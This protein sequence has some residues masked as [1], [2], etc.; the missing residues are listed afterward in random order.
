M[1]KHIVVIVPIVVLVMAKAGYCWGE[2]KSHPAISETAAANSILDSYLK[3]QLNLKNGSQAELHW[4]FPSDILKI[5][6][7]VGEDDSDKDRSINDWIRLGGTLEDVDMIRGPAWRPRHHFHN[8]INNE[9]LDNQTDHPNW[10]ELLRNVNW[11]SLG[12]IQGG[13]TPNGES[14][15]HWATKGFDRGGRVP[16]YNHYYW[17]SAREDFMRSLTLDNKTM[18]EANL[19]NALLDLG[20]VCHLLEDMG[21]PAHTRNDFIYGH[22][23]GNRWT[24]NYFEDW[25]E[26]QIVNN[27]GKLLGQWIV[28][29]QPIV[30]N[31]V[32]KYFDT[33]A[34]TGQYIGG[35]LPDSSWGLAEQTNFQFLSTSTSFECS[36]TKYQFT[37]PASNRLNNPVKEPK[38][39]GFAMYYSGYGVQHLAEESF[40][41]YIARI[42]ADRDIE[43]MQVTDKTN[44]PDVE[45][46]CK[47]YAT[48]SI[49][50][51][52]NYTTGLINYFFRGR[53][54]VAVCCPTGCY[55][56]GSVGKVRYDLTITNISK[57]TDREQVLK[58]GKFEFYWDDNSG[59]RTKLNDQQFI[60]YN[61]DPANPNTTIPWNEQ[62]YLPYNKSIKAKA[63]FDL[64][65]GKTCEDVNDF[66]IVY[67]GA[68]SQMPEEGKPIEVDEDD[69]N[70][71][72]CWTKSTSINV[73]PLLYKFYL[74]G[75]GGD[76]SLH[77]CAEYLQ[78]IY[79]IDHHDHSP[80]GPGYTLL[81]WRD[82]EPRD[83]RW[84]VMSYH[85]CDIGSW[86]CPTSCN[87]S[88]DMRIY[89]KFDSSKLVYPI[90]TDTFS[91]QITPF[92]WTRCSNRSTGT[93]CEK[94]IYKK[95]FYRDIVGGETYEDFWSR[96]FLGGVFGDGSDP[97]CNESGCKIE[98]KS[99]EIKTNSWVR[100]KWEPQF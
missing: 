77:D 52:I 23:L 25:V 35:N 83:C 58:G 55:M 51:T 32:R 10:S 64:P 93:Y 80:V 84:Q 42:K 36:G 8:P 3:E 87:V 44:T 16:V 24:A 49:P 34:Y 86:L 88:Q 28:A 5:I 26:T 53:L 67:K 39:A 78:A 74:G 75:W 27:K 11:F 41:H 12:G 33:D 6:R 9:G 29:S 4:D 40:T 45:T 82:E 96:V 99:G 21:V 57:N 85:F 90:P 60:V 70:A 73:P 95:T 68:I 2:R 98:G 97:N 66:V 63:E 92:S 61:Y 43:M 76:D 79:I 94:V 19:A 56:S 38:K 30:F 100:V 50:R 20:Q 7:E 59:N 14:A 62:S 31:T 46:V 17:W 81:H 22:F 91:V 89:S 37:N 1:K 47:D 71:I 65:A 54:D 48:I 72:A 69:P 18:R 13:W 15:A